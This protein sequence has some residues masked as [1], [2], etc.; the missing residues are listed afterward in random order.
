MYVTLCGADFRSKLSKTCILN[1]SKNGQ[2]KTMDIKALKRVVVTGMG[3]I[4]PLGPTLT[5]T[6]E[7]IVSGGGNGITSLNQ[8]LQQQHLS[9]EEYARELNLAQGLPCQV[10]AAVQGDWISNDSRTARFVKFALHASLEAVQQAGLESYLGINQTEPN[11]EIRHRRALV[12]VSI[13]NGLSSSREFSQASRLIYNEGLRRLNPHFV[14]KVLPN[15]CSG[16]VGIQFQLGG[17]SLTASSACAA[18]A[19]AIGDAFR[20]IQHGHAN[21]M[22]AGGSEAAIDP[23][24]LA[25]FGRL[26]ALSTKYNNT[27]Q[28]AS[29]PF[30]KDRDGFVMGEGSAILVL[31]EREHALQRKAPIICEVTGYGITSDGFHITSPDPKGHG[32][33]RAME[34]ALQQH[35][36]LHGSTNIDYINAHAT[37]TPMGDEIELKAIQ[38]LAENQRMNGPTFI[39]STKGATGHLLGAAG[40]LEALVSCSSIA[41]GKV[42]ATQNLLEADTDFIP[43]VNASS[44]CSTFKNSQINLVAGTQA[45]SYPVRT[46][47]SNSFGFGGTNV[48]LIFTAHIDN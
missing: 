46:A 23:L 26:R 3:C 27:P 13:G 8:A 38:R 15:S 48:S 9:E 39:S 45:I 31:E 1:L 41:S 6:W 28:L 7:A 5:S 42:P 43:L 4:S 21:V 36:T 11:D 20:A 2:A 10:A 16:R 30:D 47:M 12:G 14:P 17:P 44:I 25:G 37:S 32:A 33:Q 22:L 24:S 19:H 35:K 18:G 29:R 40:A 34:Q